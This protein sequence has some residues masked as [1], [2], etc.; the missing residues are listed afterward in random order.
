M[1]RNWVW[2]VL[3]VI[4][5]GSAGILSCG[6]DDDSQNDEDLD[7]SDFVDDPMTNCE[8]ICTEETCATVLECD[9]YVNVGGVGD[10]LE[11]CFQGCKAGCVPVGIVDCLEQFAD[12]PTLIECLTPLF[13]G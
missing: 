12:C 7:C 5:F 13:M 3:L 2:L 10:C 9:D 8:S 11:T 4:C 1:L 6:N